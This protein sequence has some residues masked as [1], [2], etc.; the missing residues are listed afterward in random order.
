MNFDELLGFVRRRSSANQIR[1][2]M[3]QSTDLFPD[4]SALETSSIEIKGSD[5]GTTKFV[6]WKL[7]TVF[8]TLYLR[9]KMTC[10]KIDL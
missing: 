8:R 9:E 3:P 4:I 7:L 2:D 5:R 10:H 1:R 6:L